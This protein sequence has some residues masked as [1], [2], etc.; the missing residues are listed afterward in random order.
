[1][2]REECEERLE[3]Q[4][5]LLR[6][7]PGHPTPP[8]RPVGLPLQ[9]K[10]GLEYRLLGGITGDELPQLASE[11]DEEEPFQGASDER[12]GAVRGAAMRR[13]GG[14]GAKHTA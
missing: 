11:N 9:Q 4:P 10:Q 7:R 2:E 13:H 3:R 1:M 8:A 12:G 14:G 5:G 6:P